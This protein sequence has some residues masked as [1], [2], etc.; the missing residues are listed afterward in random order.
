MDTMR[1]RQPPS[2]PGAAAAAMSS[3][4]YTLEASAI[5]RSR[6][7]TQ[8]VPGSLLKGEPKASAWASGDQKN[9]ELN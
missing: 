1:Q 3:E 9:A 5:P 4:S 2:V 6:E 8:H 7:W